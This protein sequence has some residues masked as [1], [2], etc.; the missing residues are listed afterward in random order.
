MWRCAQAPHRVFGQS[1]YL[2][3][4]GDFAERVAAEGFSVNTI[5]YL[6][7]LLAGQAQ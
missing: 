4:Y 7:E 6:A 1:D 5:R 3:R 2:R